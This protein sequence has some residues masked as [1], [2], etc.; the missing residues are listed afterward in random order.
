MARIVLQLNTPEDRVSFATCQEKERSVRI[1]EKTQLES[2]R[3]T[4][5]CGYL[6]QD[7]L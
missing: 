4:N 3:E 6:F 1:A 2:L 5:I 7:L